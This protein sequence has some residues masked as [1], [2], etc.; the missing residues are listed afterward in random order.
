MKTTNERRLKMSGLFLD[1]RFLPKA[2]TVSNNFIDNYMPAANGEFV[3]VY[4]LLM[5][6]NGGL[7]DD[8][9]ICSIADALGNTENDVVRALRYWEKLGLLSITTDENNEIN[10]IAINPCAAPDTGANA[11]VKKGGEGKRRR[12]GTTRKGNVG[13]RLGEKRGESDG[14]DLEQLFYII[15]MYTLRSLAE[16]DRRAI[17]GLIKKY[18]IS[19]ELVEFAA[20]CCVSDGKKSVSCIKE[21]VEGWI[22]SG[23]RTA[24]AAKAFVKDPAARI[25]AD[26]MDAFGLKN[27]DPA[28]YQMDYIRKWSGVFGFG[29]EVICEACRRTVMTIEQPSFNYADSILESWHENGVKT[30]IDIAALD[31]RFN[32]KSGGTKACGSRGSASRGAETSSGGRGSTSQGAAKTAKGTKGAGSTAFGRFPQRAY[33]YDALE[34]SLANGAR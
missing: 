7:S 3:K 23:I 34:K 10:A 15:E 22:K 27:R 32:A 6:L 1:K 12:A 25:E 19:P 21:T 26:V 33:D 17:E 9:S 2:T 8:I 4:L 20:E 13:E 30:A 28:A 24:A 18:D 29:P 11:A 5:R 31:R 14:D 16:S